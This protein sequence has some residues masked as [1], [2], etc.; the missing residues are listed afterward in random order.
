MKLDSLSQ[1]SDFSGEE[2]QEILNNALEA[3]NAHKLAIEQVMLEGK[4]RKNSGSESIAKKVKTSTIFSNGDSVAVKV[5]N[6]WIL[7]IVDKYLPNIDKYAI[8]DAEDSKQ[9]TTSPAD[10]IK[11]GEFGKFAVKSPVL[12]LFPGSSCFYNAQ[13]LKIP[14]SSNDNM[15]TLLFEDDQGMERKVESRFVLKRP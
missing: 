5:G 10:I 13:V 6:V 1:S 12:A 2:I 7:A 8:I 9:Y 15:Y 4:K 3:L 11:I 14:A